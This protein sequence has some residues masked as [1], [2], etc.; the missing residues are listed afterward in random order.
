MYQASYIHLS[1]R[2]SI[3][4]LSLLC[5]G[6]PYSPASRVAPRTESHGCVRDA[7]GRRTHLVLVAHSGDARTELVEQRWHG[8]DVRAQLDDLDACGP[9]GRRAA[10]ALCDDCG[11]NNDCDSRDD[12]SAAS[13][14]RRVI[15]GGQADL[16]RRVHARAEPLKDRFEGV[17]HLA[18]HALAANQYSLRVPKTRYRSGR[19]RV[20]VALAKAQGNER[21]QRRRRTVVACCVS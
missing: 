13:H 16:R 17:R 8:R 7:P 20:C 3:D 11:A 12:P 15:D 10:P 4:D 21:T 9:S 5:S 14:R 18:E 19:A 1:I 6:R 2:V